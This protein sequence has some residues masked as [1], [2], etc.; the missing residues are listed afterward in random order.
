MKKWIIASLLTLFS[1]EAH[2][3]VLLALLFGDKMNSERLSFGLNFGMNSTTLTNIDE[4]KFEHTFMLGLYFDIKMKRNPAWSIHPGVDIKNTFGA[5]NIFPYEVGVPELDT[6]LADSRIYRKFKLIYTYSTVRY[7]S[8][9][10]IGF[11]AGMQIGLLTRAD[12]IFMRKEIASGKDEL[13][14]SIKNSKSY[15]RIDV[16]FRGG[17][18]YKFPKG[19]GVYLNASFM[20]GMIDMPKNNPGDPMRNMGIQW[21]VSIPVGVKDKQIQIGEGDIQP[22]E[23]PAIVPENLQS[24]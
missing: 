10:G 8:K 13:V 15:H 5:K 16:S 12:D 22:E 11:D 3:Q 21:N 4:A 23:E 18:F 9:C 17:L 14:Y 1:I 7:T 19:R 6:L 24:E 20:Y 2:S